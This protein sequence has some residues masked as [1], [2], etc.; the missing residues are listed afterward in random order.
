MEGPFKFCFGPLEI[1]SEI[2]VRTLPTDILTPPDGYKDI[3][4]HSADYAEV[5]YIHIRLVIE[6]LK[7]GDKLTPLTNYNLPITLIVYLLPKFIALTN[8]V[9][10]SHKQL[11]IYSQRWH[12]W[13]CNQVYW[14][15]ILPLSQV[16]CVDATAATTN[17]NNQFYQNICK[18]K[19]LNHQNISDWS[20]DFAISCDDL[21]GCKLPY[22]LVIYYI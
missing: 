12:L 4:K 16:Q 15:G 20:A 6:G 13:C 19:E 22:F 9:N 3:S 17:W 18:Y 11:L 8:N 14:L 2:S 21:F 1:Q 5:L 7:Q 10:I